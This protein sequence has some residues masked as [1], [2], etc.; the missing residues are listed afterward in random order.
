MRIRVTIHGA[1]LATV[2]RITGDFRARGGSIIVALAK[3]GGRSREYNGRRSL[4]MRSGE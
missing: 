3:T 4:T 2:A 1:G